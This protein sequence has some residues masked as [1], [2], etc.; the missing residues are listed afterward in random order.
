MIPLL[1][2]ITFLVFA[3]INLV[4]GSPVAQYDFNPRARPEDIERIKENLGLDEPWPTRYVKW[5]GN[6]LQGDLG[7]SMINY[8]PVTSRVLNVLPNTLLLTVTALVM[9][10]VLSIPLGIYAAVKRNSFFD[11]A[12]TIG[13]VAAFAVPSFWLALMLIL[14]FSVK[15]N[16]WGLPAL[17]VSGTRTL[18]GESG[19]LDRIE[20]L[21]LPAIALGLVQIA[22]WTR[23]IRSSML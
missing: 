21:I 16:E 17:P 6:V 1:F 8:T 10:L 15:F 20:H 19:I 23:Y 3:I 7:V 14:L 9:A 5:V 11:N 2:G 13:S 12:V 18:R 22:A 4:P